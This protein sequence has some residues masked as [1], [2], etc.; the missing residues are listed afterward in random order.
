[1]TWSSFLLWAKSIAKSYWLRMAVSMCPM[2]S[3]G[4]SARWTRGLKSGMVEMSTFKSSSAYLKQK[5][6]HATLFCRT[7]MIKDWDRSS[8][9]MLWDL[10]W[11]HTSSRLNHSLMRVWGSVRR[12]WRIMWL[13][14]CSM[15]RARSPN[16]MLLQPQS[17]LW[18]TIKLL[19]QN[20]WLHRQIKPSYPIRSNL[21][22]NP[23]TK[24]LQ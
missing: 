12:S 21:N 19:Q 17:P 18:L 2:C 11:R 1:M 8:R 14:T 9:N 13:S 7:S 24:H 6:R 15:T 4:A 5:I 22:L 23:M 10:R 3:V 16:Q 20:Q